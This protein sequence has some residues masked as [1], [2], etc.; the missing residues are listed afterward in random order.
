[1]KHIIFTHALN[2]AVV[3]YLLLPGCQEER[4]WMTPST[5]EDDIILRE[6]EVHTEKAHPDFERKLPEDRP[7]LCAEVIISVPSPPVVE[8]TTE[9]RCTGWRAAL[10]GSGQNKLCASFPVL[11]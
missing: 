9:Y 10:Q 4:S 7:I 6:P 3:G 1:M 11:R 8:E 5:V 2:L